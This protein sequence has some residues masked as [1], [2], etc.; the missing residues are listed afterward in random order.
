MAGA[1]PRQRIVVPFT[2]HR[3]GEGFNS[4]TAERV[5]VALD[6]PSVGEDPVAPGQTASFKFLMLTS[7]ES[8]EKALN[9]GV[10]VEARYALLSGGAKFEF[11][12]SS[13]VNSTSTYIVASCVVANALRFGSGFTPTEA[14]KRMI[15]AGDEDGF[16]TSFGDRFTQALH[17]GGEFYAVVRLTSSSVE[18]QRKVS[19]SLHAELNGLVTSG[20]FKGSLE[21]AEKDASSHIEVDIQVH[22][23]GGVGGQI[24]IP[25]TEADRIREHMNRFAEAAHANAA[26]YAAELLTYETLALPFPPA[27]ELEE[28]RL[29]LEDCLTRRRAYWSAISQLAF[30]Q[31]EEAALIFDDLPPAAELLALQNEF[32]RVLNDLMAHARAVSQ[33]TTP[34]QFFVATNEPVLPRFKR[35]NASHFAVWWARSKAKDPTLLRDEQLLINGIA[36]EVEPMLTVPLEDASPETM[37]RAADT[38]EFLGINTGGGHTP[39]TR[40]KSLRALPQMLDAPIRT[41]SGNFTDLRDL[42]GIEAFSRLEYVDFSE[43]LLVDLEAIAAV[44]GLR[45]LILWKNQLADLAPL[46]ALTNLRSLHL[47]ENQVED[48]AP[49][50]EMVSLES[51]SIV[52]N[53][54]VSLDPLGDLPNLKVLSIN[55]RWYDLQGD[56][57]IRDARALARSPRLAN[58]L[59]TADQLRLTVCG[60]D[61][62]FIRATTATRIAATNRFQLVPDG[63]GDPEEVQIQGIGEWRDFGLFPAPVVAIAVRFPTGEVGM[64]CT[65]PE[66]RSTTLFAVEMAPLLPEP[67]PEFPDG[68][69]PGGPFSS[70][71]ETPCPHFLLETQPVD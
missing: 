36:R 28:R 17:T 31:S 66:D 59:T 56:N 38:L 8:F 51:L 45:Q 2:G 5:G 70:A 39:D 30:A 47:M 34:A 18:H 40:P 71:V 58:P 68:P 9:I 35:S 53:R 57:P 63:G 41:I 12:E 61:G 52:S 14:A 48:L 29:V 27:E 1:P 10:E 3:I 7:Q 69:S 50:A 19:A 44:A 65:R 22:Q 54:V 62:A 4:D 21:D 26:A 42:A 25:G 16:K 67:G 46:R 49:L 20:S 15:A 37:E 60:R 32:R 11:A 43:G 24:Q 55:S 23:T 33:G 64:A 6:V 13:A